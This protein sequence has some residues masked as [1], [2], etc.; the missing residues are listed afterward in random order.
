MKQGASGTPNSGPIRKWW[1]IVD[2]RIGIVPL[3]VFV[4]ILGLVAAFVRNGHVPSDIL[5]NMAVLAVGGF[6]CAEL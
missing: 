1:A 2:F 5:T 6:A 3:P 4:G